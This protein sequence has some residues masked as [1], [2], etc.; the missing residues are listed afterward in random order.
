MHVIKTDV[1]KKISKETVVKMPG[2]THLLIESPIFFEF[3]EK[4][5]RECLTKLRQAVPKIKNRWN[6]KSWQ[7]VIKTGEL[8]L[9]DKEPKEIAVVLGLAPSTIKRY[10]K[11]LDYEINKNM[12][13]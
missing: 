10:L 1:I 2:S 6:R 13:G 3:K 7:R 8:L 11:H 5:L 4:S 12:T 9:Q